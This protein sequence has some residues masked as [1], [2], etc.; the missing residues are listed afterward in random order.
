MADYFQLGPSL[1]RPPYAGA[2]SNGVRYS[3][4]MTTTALTTVSGDTIELD[5]LE[6]PSGARIEQLNWAIGG[7][8]GTGTSATVVLRKK[9]SNQIN[10]GTQTGT[11]PSAADA[12]VPINGA[13]ITTTANGQ[14]SITLIPSNVEGVSKETL[15]EPY[16]LALKIATT[17]TSFAAQK[18]F[19]S[20]VGKFVGTN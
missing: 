12:T 8:L 17:G 10:V 9:N 13:T 18:V 20:A 5:L 1:G 2:N 15:Q 6:L 16:I 7:S 3:G 4:E 11:L 14:G 19:L